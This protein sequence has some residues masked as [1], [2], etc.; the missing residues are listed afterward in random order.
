MKQNTDS[1]LQKA[2]E[3]TK[4]QLINKIKSSDT[5]RFDQML[6][7][8]EE[9]KN[10]FFLK[11]NSVA[12]TRKPKT[13]KFPLFKDLVNDFEKNIEE[14][15]EIKILE[16]DAIIQKIISKGKNPMDTPK[17]SG[18]NLIFSDLKIATENDKVKIKQPIVSFQTK[19]Y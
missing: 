9:R 19:V 5:T 3:V 8:T 12:Y 2:K 17:Y 4:D 10:Y 1:R 14:N 18:K 11:Y 16:N 6:I 7:E 15:G 13:L